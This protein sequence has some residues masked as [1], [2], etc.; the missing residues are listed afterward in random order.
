MKKGFTLI[1]LLA[2]IIILS[3]TSMIIF[4]NVTKVINN[5]KNDLYNAQVLDIQLAAEK[6]SSS[7]VNLLDST[8]AN[9]V[10]IS[11]EA[12]R[13]S[14][15]LEPDP[16]KSPKDR[17]IMNGCIQVKYNP[18]NKKYNHVYLEKSCRNYASEENDEFGSIIYSY[19]RS[20]KKFVKDE[21]SKEVVSTGLALY[22]LNQKQLK[23]RGQSDSGLY[24]LDSEY[25]FRGVE[26]NNFVTLT[27]VDGNNI[28]NTSWRVLSIDKEN[29]K[30]KL[31][32]TTPIA[33]NTWN[34][35]NS[36]SFRNSALNT[37]LLSK[38]DGETT[39]YTKKIINND[40]QIGSV[41]SSESSIDALKS[42]L[43]GDSGVDNTSS[44]KVGTISV[45]DYVNASASDCDSNFLSNS[46]ATNNYLKTMFGDSSTT[47]TLNTDGT[48]VWYVNTNGMLSLTSPVNNKQIY[49]VVTLDSNTYISN[50]DTA[51]GTS[52]NPYIIK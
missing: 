45:L 18:S 37:L 12:L 28:R 17:S 9:T 23:T 51:T 38:T 22:N 2:V 16:I 31:I 1:E 15:F 32:S 52:I 49:A 8:H 33:T 47:W 20:A 41:P 30:V 10:Y 42:V 26:P 46:C 11:L 36:I 25:V 3:I 19:D 13:F 7:N 44:Q 35:T 24:D 29:Y 39:Y 14:G 50:L 40:Y 4:P 34:N 6:W 27:G 21:S 5:S 43:S 48:Q